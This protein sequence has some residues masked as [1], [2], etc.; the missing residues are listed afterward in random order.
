[1]SSAIPSPSESRDSQLALSCLPRMLRFFVFSFR[2]ALR[3]RRR[4][5]A[6]QVGTTGVVCL[7]FGC[8]HPNKRFCSI[9]ILVLG[10]DMSACFALLRWEFWR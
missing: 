5:V 3:A 2:K 10:E 4:K 7:V 8:W 1:M 6:S 9:A